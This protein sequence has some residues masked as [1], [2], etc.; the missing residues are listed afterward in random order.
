V[1]VVAACFLLAA[2]LHGAASVAEPGVVAEV[3]GKALPQDELQPGAKGAQA[4]EVRRWLQNQVNDHE[5]KVRG[6]VVTEA[7]QKAWIEKEMEPYAKVGYG[8]KNFER[9]KKKHLKV[10]ALA[11]L[12]LDNPEEAERKFR[13]QLQGPDPFSPEQWASIKA[14]FKTE[15]DIKAS[16]AQTPPTAKEAV[17]ISLARM[18][19]KGA[20]LLKLKEEISREAGKPADEQ[21]LLRWYWGLYG[22]AEITFCKGQSVDGSRLRR[23]RD[24][25][26]MG[27][28]VGLELAN[29]G[30]FSSQRIT[31]KPLDRPELLN[32][33]M[34]KQLS[35]SPGQGSIL[36]EGPGKYVLVVLISKTYRDGASFQEARGSI[37]GIVGKFQMEDRYRSWLRDQIGKCAKI[38]DPELKKLV[39]ESLGN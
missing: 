3:F 7:D 38:P 11:R 15:A 19:G 29:E 39:L 10:L 17:R 16:E 35:L 34:L 23:V 28:D 6:L 31:I 32:E 12:H 26:E 36:E 4:I 24:K 13:D 5:I 9:G 8:E 33:K 25:V 2:P 14:G 37:A 21:V 18:A 22:V 1:A 20:L 30:I 27:A